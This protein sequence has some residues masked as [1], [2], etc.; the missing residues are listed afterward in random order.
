MKIGIN[1]RFLLKGRLE[2]I[3]WFCNEIIR[4]MVVL[5]PQHQF[6]L[7]FDRPYSKEFIYGVN[8]EAVMIW[9]PARHPV[10]W[11]FW[12][13]WALPSALKKHKVDL[14]ISMDG[15]CSLKSEIPQFLVLH[16]LA[17]LHF[18]KQLN[19]LVSA[20]YKFFV[21]R[22]L[23]KA[24]H[25]FAVSES[26][27]HDIV[28][29]YDIPS[30]KIDVCYNGVREFFLKLIPEEIEKTRKKYSCGYPYFLFVGALH[31]RKNVDGLIRAFQIFKRQTGSAFYLL[32]VGR[33]AWMTKEMED[34]Y[35]QSS[36][37]EEIVFLEHIESDE[38]AKITG[39]AAAAIAPSFLEGFGVPVLEALSCEVPVLCSNAY[40]LPEVAGPGAYLFNPHDDES[41][42][43]AMI[44]FIWDKN[45]VE[46]IQQGHEHR[47]QFSWEYTTEVIC[48]EIFKLSNEI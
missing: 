14:F 18:P 40:S 15:Y 30:S 13:E 26:T 41:I 38:L 2:G 22:Y 17:F 6:V 36:F 4:R 39:A 45:V 23:Q 7:F 3:G 25:V 33:K 19:W 31:P 16:D 21:P 8:V 9:P 5:Y 11:Y 24:R 44:E 32:I 46:R 1:A 42:A 27:K 10:L 35:K 20:Y 48:N 28:K 43:H 34:A 37:K 29:H 47:Q 12:F